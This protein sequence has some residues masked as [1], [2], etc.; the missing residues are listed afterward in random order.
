MAVAYGR[1]YQKKKERSVKRSPA[2]FRRKRTRTV[3]HV[4][5]ACIGI[6]VLV[7][8][9]ASWR[10]IT[11]PAL[12]R[13]SI[14]A[15]GENSS[16]VVSW[17]AQRSR[18]MIMKIPQDVA[19]DA[20]HSLGTYSIASLFA[21]DLM[22]A[23]HGRMFVGSLSES[24]GVPLLWYAAPG[25]L[26]DSGDVGMIRSLFSFQSI[27]QRSTGML[28][29]TV[30]LPVWAGWVIAAQSLSADSVELVH[31][32]NAFV[33]TELP[34]GSVIR[35][36]DQNRLDFFVG[37]SFLDN[38]IRTES[39]S[40]SVFNTT[41][42]PAVSTLAARQMHTVGIQLVYVGNADVSIE[43]ACVV[44]GDETYQHSTTVRFLREYFGCR[45]SNDELPVS[46]QPSDLN[47]Y[48]GNAYVSRYEEAGR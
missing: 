40:V 27:W 29:T 25:K 20:L 26:D 7:G 16:Y 10:A 35:T 14:I 9:V 22:Q 41:R 34:D 48:F 23:Y 31:I 44:S 30:P 17:N 39:V 1:N 33:R 6:V 32:D 5:A 36:I 18:V 38:T 28:A 24:L 12:Y 45:W 8:A 19:I 43:D 46:G 13:Q 42:T 21:L 47:V 2:T 15:V 37:T 4:L 3:R 11:K